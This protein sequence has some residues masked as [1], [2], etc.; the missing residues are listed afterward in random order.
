[1]SSHTFRCANCGAPLQSGDGDGVHV[2]CRYC[3][4]ENVLSRSIGAGDDPATKGRRLQ[5][6]AVEAQ[7]LAK[8]N[9][10]RSAA[11]M[12]EF[13]ALSL[14]AHQGDREAAEEAVVLMEGYL[15]LQYAPTVHMYTSYD[16][17]DP[18]VVQAMQQ[19]DTA[20]HQALAAVR[21]SFG[22]PPR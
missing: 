1:M 10:E 4:A 19:I 11:L 9:E 18:A 12:A 6:A 17:T 15:R 7:A 3:R 2:R 5:L 14:A 16:P 21:E 22:L 8:R 13:E 20:V